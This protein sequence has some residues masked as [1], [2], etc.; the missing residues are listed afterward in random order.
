MPPSA[1]ACAFHTTATTPTIRT[2]LEPVR[3][4]ADSGNDETRAVDALQNGDDVDREDGNPAEDDEDA[5]HAAEA[6]RG[7]A[8][9]GLHHDVRE[10]QD[11]LRDHQD[12]AKIGRA[13]CRE[14]V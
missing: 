14:R 1:I 4:I 10:E 12:D 6:E 11:E 3:V 2:I 13:S 9:Q 5:Q 7:E 8:D